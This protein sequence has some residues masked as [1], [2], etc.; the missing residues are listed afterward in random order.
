MN[1]RQFRFGELEK[2][3]DERNRLP[4]S[5]RSPHLVEAADR[6]PDALEELLDDDGAH[7][8]DLAQRLLPALVRLQLK[9]TLGFRSRRVHGEEET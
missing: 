2:S 9:R 6:L 1:E 8:G 3:L 5:L 7:H 4:P